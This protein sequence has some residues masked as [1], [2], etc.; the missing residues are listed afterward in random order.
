MNLVKCEN[1][2][3]Y[4]ADKFL[5]C[6]HCSNQLAGTNE[7][8]DSQKKQNQINTEPPETR[9]RE[10]R[11]STIS[12]N[13]VGWLV[14]IEGV[15]QGENFTLREGSNYIGR[16]AS[17]DVPLLYEPTVSREKHAVITYDNISNSY[18]LSSPEYADRTFCNG[19]PVPTE[20]VLKNRD[21]ITLGDCSLLFIALCN[22][23]FRW[24][25]P[26]EEQ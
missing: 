15:S 12:G 25:V 3:F 19:K 1:E 14:C 5:F 10:S 2:H 23:S 11:A 4:D 13:T 24:P 6:P 8:T 21:L 26:K 16:A 20:K 17:M 18:L 22:A 7:M 9:T